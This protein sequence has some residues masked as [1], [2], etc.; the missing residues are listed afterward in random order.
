MRSIFVL[1]LLGVVLIS[2]ALMVRSGII[3]REN[4]GLPINAAMRAALGDKAHQWTERDIG[5]IAQNYPGA[6]S[7][8]TGLRYIV[9]T[10][11][12]GESTPQR[13]QIVTVHYEGRF[14]DGEIVFDTSANREGPLNFRVGEGVV[15]PGWDEGVIAMKKGEK[16]TLIVPYWLA[17]G[18]KG[19]RGKIRPHAT[20][21]F[22]IE[23]LKFE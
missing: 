5:L 20:L 14:L 4:P 11:G 19:I 7:L 15:I 9:R 12:T 16:R 21:V 18:E 17:Y 2:I 8:P 3:S 1:T 6:Q 22:D 10:P 23:L 13:G